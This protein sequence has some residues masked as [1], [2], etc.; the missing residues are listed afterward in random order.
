MKIFAYL[1]SYA[2][3]IVSIFFILVQ[4]ISFG[5]EKVQKWITS[6]F[7]SILTSV[8]LTQPIQVILT[9][10]FFA[11]V[12]RKATD[13]YKE[14]VEEDKKIQKE[15]TTEEKEDVMPAQVETAT[16]AS[17]EFIRIERKKQQTVKNILKKLFLHSMFLWILYVTSFSNRDL[18]SYKYQSSLKKIL[19]NNVDNFKINSV[20]D[21][22]R[23]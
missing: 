11:S 9:A 20:N 3:A 10:I 2:C 18:N 5:N 8:F 7:F 15:E 14:N 21:D 12:F 23:A 6:L 4:G 17:L 16:T 22:V 1:F 19:T 13:L